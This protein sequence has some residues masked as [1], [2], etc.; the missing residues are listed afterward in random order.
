MAQIK[1][2][3]QEYQYSQGWTTPSGHEFHQYETPENE[4]FV[5]KHASG[6]HVEFKADGSIFIHA[7]KDIHYTSSTLSTQVDSETSSKG[8]E[9]TT[10]R[11]GTNFTLDCLGDFNLKCRRFNLEIGQTG[12]I[13]AGEDL[14]MKA[15]NSMVRGSESVAVEGTKSIYMDTDEMV[16]RAVAQKSEIGTDE[17]KGKGGTNIINLNG[18][19]VINNTDANGGITIA[20]KG[21]LNLVCGQERIDVVGKYEGVKD[22]PSQE[23]V[24][25]FTTKVYQPSEGGGQDLSGVPGDMHVESDA[26]ITFIHENK[27]KGSTQNPKDGRNVTLKKGDDT[28]LVQKGDQN[29]TIEKGDQNIKVA[30]GKLDYYVKDKVKITFDDEYEQKVKKDVTREVEEGDEKLTIGGEYTVKAEKIYLN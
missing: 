2:E 17:D 27:A 21:Y 15:K 6:S 26:G 28:L 14:E 13:T 12:N 11:I 23:G 24:S 20:S 30:Q 29:I 16:T 25:T 1:D 18:H 5:V 7:L 22:N 19:A 9:V 4:R 10:N 8:A 3:K